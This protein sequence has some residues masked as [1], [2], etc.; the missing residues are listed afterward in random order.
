M[1]VAIS[2]GGCGIAVLLWVLGE[3]KVHPPK[4]VL[5][6]LLVVAVMLIVG[7]W[8]VLR[9]RRRRHRPNAL[10]VAAASSGAAFPLPRA[11]GGHPAGPPPDGS[12]GGTGGSGSIGGGAGGSA[13]PGSGAGGGQGGGGYKSTIHPDGSLTFE[14]VEGGLGGDGGGKEG[15][16]GGG[17]VSPATGNVTSYNQSGGITAHT[18]VSAPQ[19]QVR[20]HEEWRNRLN[21]DGEYVTLIQLDLEDANASHSLYIRATAASLLRI[22]VDAPGERGHSRDRPIDAEPD[23]AFITISHPGEH[24]PVLAFTAEPDIVELVCEPNGRHPT[25]PAASDHIRSVWGP[26]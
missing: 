16:Q 19:T 25:P 10:E 4:V 17:N 11:E 8:I 5:Y 15:G 22:V 9:V 21:A 3:L 6:L 26:A 18:V 12:R 7:P 14:P 24:Y 23:V 20:M 2:L 1:P 13:P